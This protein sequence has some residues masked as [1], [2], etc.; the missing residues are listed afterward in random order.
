MPRSNVYARSLL[1]NP[2]PHS[3][4]RMATIQGNPTR[5]D[6]RES[7]FRQAALRALENRLPNVVQDAMAI[8]AGLGEQYIWIGS[9]CIVQD[10]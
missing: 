3:Q 10:D 1:D 2:V 8:T 5:K 9:R 4:L 6:N 7:L